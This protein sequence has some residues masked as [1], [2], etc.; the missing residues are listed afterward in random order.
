LTV[1]FGTGFDEEA[2]NRDLAIMEEVDED[3]AHKLRQWCEVRGLRD[4]IDEFPKD[5]KP[6][7]LGD[8]FD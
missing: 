6:S 7:D 8:L 4:D 3:D 2:V 1:G 5:G